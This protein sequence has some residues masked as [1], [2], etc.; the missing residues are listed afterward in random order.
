MIKT[1]DPA[2]KT[3]LFILG[4]GFLFYGAGHAFGDPNLKGAGFF[5]FGASLSAFRKC[6]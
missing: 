4:I 6:A 1:L 2:M 5:F 3:F